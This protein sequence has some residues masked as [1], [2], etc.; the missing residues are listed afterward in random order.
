V[1]TRLLYACRHDTQQVLLAQANLAGSTATDCGVV[2]E[3][4]DAL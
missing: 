4:H 3:L 2:P 1:R